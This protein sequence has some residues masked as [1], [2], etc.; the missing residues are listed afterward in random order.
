VAPPARGTAWERRRYALWAPIYDFVVRPFRAARR[1]SVEAMALRP[2]DRLLIVGGGTG[3][4]LPLIPAGVLTVLTDW[5]PAMLRRAAPK[6]QPGHHVAVMDG[7]ALAMADESVDAVLLHLILAVI[8]DPARCLAE[9]A[10]VVRSGGRMAV[11]DKFVP[12]GGR[13]SPARRLLNR[14]TRP[15][16][17]D[18]TRRLDDIVRD[19]GAKVTR[20]LDER[21]MGGRFSIVQLRRE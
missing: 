17:T 7:H 15:I 11:F 8:P 3:E 9:A 20:V 18:I 6:M 16:A 1:R 5:S 13:A 14:V 19:S 10:R 4:D 12:D 21:A 2:G